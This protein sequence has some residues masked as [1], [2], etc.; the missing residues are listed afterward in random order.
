MLPRP[1]SFPH[2][3]RGLRDM[4]RTEPHARFHLLAAVA[5]VALGLYLDVTRVDWLALTLAIAIVWTAEALNTAVERTCD[6]ITQERDERIRIAKDVA[7]GAVLL[8]SVAAV[9]IA[10][11]VFGPHLGL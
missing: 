2:A 5:V 4:L 6:A 3:L 8:A 10:A 11:L 1:K 9:V 7:A